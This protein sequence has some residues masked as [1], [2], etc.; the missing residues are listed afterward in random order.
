[1]TDESVQTATLERPAGEPRLLTPAR[2]K[3]VRRWWRRKPIHTGL[4]WLHRWPALVLGLF[5]VAECTSG[6]LLLYH[7]EYWRA[8]HGSFYHHT[9]SA[10]PLT[11]P[12]ALDAVKRADPAFD[13][14]WASLDDGVIVVG[15]SAYHYAHAV[16]PGSGHVSGR[17][18]LNSGPMGFLENLHDCAFTC[19]GDPG[20]VSWLGKPVWNGGPTFLT[21]ITW[22][23]LI[24]GV[25]G[26]LMILLFFTGLKIWWPK[27]RQLGQRFYKVRSGRGASGRFARDYDLHNVIAAWSMPFILMWGI[28]GA[29]FEFPGVEN[30]WLAITGGH[31]PDPNA[32]AFD[33]DKPESTTQ[34]T[35]AQATSIALAQVPGEVRYVELAT[36]DVPYWAVEVKTDWAPY[37]HRLF[38]SGDTYVYVDAHD[39]GHTKVVGGPKENAAN[40]F[41]DRSLEATH[42]GWNVNA[43]W[44]ILWFVLGMAPFALLVTGVS[45]WL[46]RRG[47]RKRRRAAGGTA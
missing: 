36:K 37:G 8:T 33:T 11:V 27:L 30:A 20:Y 22:A 29:A 25:L 5:L 12:Q 43:W 9:A 40:R 44:R 45:T 14:A 4:V 31:K 7:A 34:V 1:M 41:Y 21:G 19:E 32:Y 15:D 18:D 24:L 10:D 3:A 26:C 23:A 39:P 6:A 2:R 16:D 38:Y 28:T 17:T 47:V 46:Y 13:A 35:Y 42:F